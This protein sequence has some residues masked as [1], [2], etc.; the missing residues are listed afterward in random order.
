MRIDEMHMMGVMVDSGWRH[1]I[2]DTACN[3]QLGE[4]ASR[5]ERTHSAHLFDML[6]KSCALKHAGG[7]WH[8]IQG[9]WRD[10]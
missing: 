6:D 9:V 4:A 3:P 7:A 1:N 2:H 8:S 5:V 10:L